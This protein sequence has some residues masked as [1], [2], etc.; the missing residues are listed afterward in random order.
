MILFVLFGLAWSD[1]SLRE[2][3]NVTES[4][5]TCQKWNAF[6]PHVPKMTPVFDNHNRFL[7]LFNSEIRTLMLDALI[8]TVMQFLG[9]TLLI[10]VNDG[11]IV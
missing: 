8:Q 3:P 1:C 11:S 6:Y 2:A 7:I 5:Y 4:G 9:A 10:R